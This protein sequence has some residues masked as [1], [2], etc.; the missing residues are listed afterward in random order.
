[1]VACVLIPRFALR[2]ASPDGLGGAPAA[3]APPPGARPLLGEVSRAAESRGVRPGMALGEA[4]ARCPALRLL[5]ADPAR[6][7]E[8]WEG[9]LSRL[10]GIGAAVESE[11]AG[12]AF[13]CVGG[14]R[15]LHGGEV[16][17]VLAA[18]R[19]AAGLPVRIAAA[20]GRFAA[21]LAAER[22]ERLPRRAG[23]GSGE[24]IVP[25]RAL[26]AFLGPHPVAA[27]RGRLGAT[28][29]E[30]EELVG[31]LE[32]LGIGTLARLARLSDDQAADRFG[33]LGLRALRLAR[34]EDDPLRP[35]P[36]REELAVE[37]ELPE[38]CAGAQLERALELLVARLLAAPQRRGRTLLA[39]RL[40]APLCG[41]GSW[42]AEQG[43]GRPS[44]R[45]Q[46][47]ASLL[48]P[49]LEALPGPAGALRLR[50]LAL[51]PPEGDQL[52]LGLD[53]N[54]PR[55]RRLAGALREVRAAA[56][57][58]SLLRVVDLDPRSRLP[59][60]RFA[61]APYPEPGR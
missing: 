12:E 47:I 29:V 53:G 2:A 25:A 13:F 11:R 18:A 10:E 52:E 30:Q 35:R 34:G 45:A 22:A 54:E 49:R 32:R 43:L 44:A 1:M 14:L 33:A 4:L 16:A 19:E 42:S 8:L 59:E 9:L 26:R 60:R 61:L 55:R 41:G 20:P 6:A 24:A 36:P 38:G 46:T 37:I 57:A 7:A 40:Q 17:G 58:E 5:P 51:G 21:S 27:L 39:L 23:R 15:G 56:G 48:A 31:A 28:E 50:A 3:L